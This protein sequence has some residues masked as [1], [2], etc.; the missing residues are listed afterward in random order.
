MLA[1]LG[2]GFEVLFHDVDCVIDLL[3]MQSGVSDCAL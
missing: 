2:Y 3:F 1:A